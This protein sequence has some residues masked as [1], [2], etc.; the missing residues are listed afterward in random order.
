MDIP[1]RIQLIKEPTTYTDEESQV[2]GSVSIIEQMIGL[3]KDRLC[4]CGL[5]VKW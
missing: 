1:K 3:P 4:W 5:V 2:L